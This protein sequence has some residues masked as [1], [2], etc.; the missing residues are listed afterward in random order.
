[1]VVRAEAEEVTE[2]LIKEARK[3]K[4]KESVAYWKNHLKW[5]KEQRVKEKASETKVRTPKNKRGTKP[6][7]KRADKSR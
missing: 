7:P 4:D 2:R 6:K 1:M 3:K 5:I